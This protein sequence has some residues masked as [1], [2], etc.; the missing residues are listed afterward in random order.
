MV[1]FA[2]PAALA[3]LA[4][5]ACA[6]GTT[7]APIG[8]AALARLSTSV[9]AG[10]P[11]APHPDRGPTWI[12]PEVETKKT[13][14]LFVSDSYA[15][16][17]YMYAVPSLKV[18]GTITGF[19]QPQG[20]CSDSKGDVWITDT[21]A[22]KIYEVSHTGRL[23]TTLSD[24][25]GYP[26]ACAW[27]AKSGNVAVMNIFN[28]LGEHGEVIVYPPGSKQPATY[29]NSHQ[30][31]Y[32]FG[33]YDGSGDLF[34]DGRSEGGAF[35]LSELPAGARSAET[36]KVSGA[37]IYFPGMVQMSTASSDVLVGDQECG[38]ASAACIYQLTVSGTTAKVTGT[39]KL[40]SGMGGA[41]CDLVQGVE[42]NGEIAGSDWEFCGYTPSTTDLWAY[43]S[44]GKPSAENDSTDTQPVGTALSGEAK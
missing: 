22:Q 21:N 43:P 7:P 15:D 35:M 11:A 16:V 30:Y 38:N 39:A 24:G 33:G 27:D 23:L 18:M 9:A 3:A 41:V 25:Y 29:V 12:S 8:P 26:V 36:I 19:Q 1:R 28:L 32:D 5:A 14:L 10:W 17:V 2:V 40:E 13:Q 20:E 6:G 37:R 44:G 4:L 34:F 31:Y 42:A